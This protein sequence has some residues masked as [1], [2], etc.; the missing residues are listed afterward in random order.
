MISHFH[1][2]AYCLIALLS[3]SL[4]SCQEK[5][6]PKPNILFIA[7]DD[8]RPELGAYGKEYVHSPT[9]DA[10]AA[11]GSLFTNHYV[12]VPTCGASRYNLLTGILPKTKTEIGN[13]AAV[14]LISNKSSKERPKTF[15]NELRENGYYTVG[16]GKISHHPDGYVYGYQEPKS[17]IIELPESW[18]EMLFDSGKWGTG[19]NAFFGYADGSNRNDKNKQ[20]K[21]YESA[22]VGDE[23]YPDGLTANLA[24]QKLKELKQKGQPFFLG[25]G[26]F[27][28]HLPFTA[29]K[30]Y[31]D[32]YNEGDIPLAPFSAIPENS[33]KSSLQE[34]GEFNQYSLGEEKAGLDS[35]MS[36]AYS[37]KI[38]HGYL[39][40]IS[41]ID[42]QI[43]KVIHSLEEQGLAENTIIVLWGDHGWHLGDQLTWGKH[44]VFE[45]ALK[46]VLIIKRPGHKGE[47]IDQIVSTTDIYPTIMEMLQLESS[48]QLDGQSM[49]SL[50]DDPSTSQWRNTAYS[51]FRNGISLRVP[52]YRMTRYFR[53]ISPEV[54]L[55]DLKNDPNETINIADKAPEQVKRLDPIWQ[56]GNTGI[57]QD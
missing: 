14:K 7:I 11:E 26:F 15:L 4:L 42:A 37:R 49:V 10:I 48:E 12:T 18:D 56:K 51:Y 40:A 57:F 3:L 45:S 50:M 34:S 39:A 43:G 33:S 32:L 1:A 46:S 53:K 13:D 9:M 38:R 27:K 54:E 30:K 28:P 5:V 35:A 6:S 20:V 16:I 52:D 23:G 8:L 19:H 24:V 47:K 17:D 21:P 22:D 2:G 44:T 31:W 41:Y 36:D 55:Y 29:P 25:L